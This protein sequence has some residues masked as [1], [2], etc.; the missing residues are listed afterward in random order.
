MHPITLTV[1]TGRCGTSFLYHSLYESFVD[2]ERVSNP[3][4]THEFLDTSIVKTGKTHRSYNQDDITKLKKIP[5]VTALIDRWSEISRTD[6]VVDFGWTMRSLIP[7][8]I[9]LFGMRVKIIF[10]HR[11]PVEISASFANMGAYYDPSYT[12]DGQRKIWSINPGNQKCIHS[13]YSQRW[14][15][16]SRFEKCLFMWLEV[17]EYAAELHQR[18][19][20]N[21]YLNVSSSSLFS[22]QET[23]NKV[24]KFCGFDGIP[25]RS[26]RK[27][28]LTQRSQEQYPLSNRE[29]LSVFSHPEV[30]SMANKLG[31]ELT[32]ENVLDST[33]KYYL[34]KGLFPKL[35]HHSKYWHARESISRLKK[36]ILSAL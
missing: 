2:S 17:S 28:K 20:Q 24:A 9:D 14:S 15:T 36:S 19:P 7:M 6:P 11:N 16:M 22:D 3:W 29:A 34:P 31:Y 21:E 27:N 4:I 25:L 13:E 33:K 30:I 23:L 26:S 12:P 5:E 35:R 8:F 10:V 1:S 32:E 18:F